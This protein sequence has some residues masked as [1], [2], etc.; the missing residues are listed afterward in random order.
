MNDTVKQ[1]Q[2]SEA[3]A[4]WQWHRRLYNWVV[5]WADTRF[6]TQALIA[7]ALTE[8]ICVPIP[9]DV[10][11]IGLCL[12]RP[13]RSIRYGTAQLRAGSFGRK[14]RAGT[15]ALSQIRLLGNRNFGPDARAI[16]AV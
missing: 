11:V 9:A 14:G 10:M 5:H 12:G 7:L 6:G 2:R 3:V 4:R 1:S 8:P 15:G 13:K 16:Y